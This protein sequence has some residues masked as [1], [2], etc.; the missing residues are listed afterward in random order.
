MML[1]VDS[2]DG[3]LSLAGMSAHC[4]QWTANY[5]P[6]HWSVAGALIPLATNNHPPG[7]AR[8]DGLQFKAQRAKM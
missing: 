6:S 3:S 5:L 8:P 1:M 7:A 2:V 4:S